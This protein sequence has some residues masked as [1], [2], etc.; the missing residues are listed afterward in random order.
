MS[1]VMGQTAGQASPMSTRRERIAWYLY[2]FGNSAYAAVVL[3]AI[4][5]AYF[6]GEVVGGAQGSRLWGY[7]VGS[8]CSSWPS[9]RP[10]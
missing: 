1:E 3:L 9:L 8:P 2:D 4:Y 10:C 6:Q 7:A 5:S